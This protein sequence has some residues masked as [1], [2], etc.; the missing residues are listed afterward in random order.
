METT[1]VSEELGAA[2][3]ASQTR[4]AEAAEDVRALMARSPRHEVFVARKLV[5]LDLAVGRPLRKHVLLRALLGRNKADAWLPLGDKKKL[6][7][8]R[9]DHV[10]RTVCTWFDSPEELMPVL[11]HAAQ[12]RTDL[13]WVWVE[14]VARLLEGGLDVPCG[15]LDAEHYDAAVQAVTRTYVSNVHV[16]QGER[17]AAV[18][19]WLKPPAQ[20]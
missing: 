11:V 19:A 5:L 16:F 10:V 20:S 18:Q 8:N 12:T 13:S 14:L 3:A 15:D 4:F 7:W 1:R 6:T 2:L 9:V 17:Y